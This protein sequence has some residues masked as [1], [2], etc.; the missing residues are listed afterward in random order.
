MLE[1][2][3]PRASSLPGLQGTRGE[4][5]AAKRRAW[6]LPRVP[7][8]IG[9]CIAW[10]VGLSLAALFAPALAEHDPLKQNL[11]ARNVPPVWMDGGTWDHPLG[12]DQLGYDLYSRTLH[13]ARPALQIA[14]TAALISLLIGT[15]LGL[16]AGYFR[17]PL[18]AVIMLVVDAQLSTPFMV[19]AIAAVAAFGRSLTLLII[20]AGIS[21]WMAFARTIRAQ[22]LSLRERE[23]I[24]ASHAIGASNGRILRH[25]L[26]PNLT[27]Y[28]IVLVT[29]QIRGLILFEASMSF[30]GLGVPPPHPSWGSMISNG[31][32]YLLSSWWISIVP[33]VALM[34]T[35]LAASLF[36]DWLRD[37]LD[38]TLRGMR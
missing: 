16:L 28:I 10:L 27:T 12:T 29:V 37:R 15:T 30:L 4:M 11:R 13:G 38:P 14:A 25:H 32:D 21:G 26:L 7:I 22:V 2:T 31:R 1:I 8:L 23:F 5:S 33:G 36:G 9:L 19:I 6:R 20:L 3:S 17:G 34:T 24:H 35:V 18:D